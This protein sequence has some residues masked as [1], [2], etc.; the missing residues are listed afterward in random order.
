[1]E[2]FLCLGAR[3]QATYWEETVERLRRGEV[4]NCKACGCQYDARPGLCTCSEDC[5]G[6][7]ALQDPSAIKLF[8]AAVRLRPILSSSDAATATGQPQA[9]EEYFSGLDWG[10]FDGSNETVDHQLA[11][12]W[13]VGSEQKPPAVILAE[14]ATSAQDGTFQWETAELL[15][16]LIWT[17]E[18]KVEAE[19]M[20]QYVDA[21]YT[22]WDNVENLV[23]QQDELYLSLAM[24]NK[25]I[26]A[27]FRFLADDISR[28][29]VRD[30]TQPLGLGSTMFA[31]LASNCENARR[32]I[33][34]PHPYQKA[35]GEYSEMKLLAM[36]AGTPA[37]MML[38]WD[39]RLAD[40]FAAPSDEYLKG[41]ICALKR[42]V[43]LCIEVFRT[44]PWRLHWPKD[45][46]DDEI[47]LYFSVD[48]S[49]RFTNAK[50]ISGAMTHVTEF[51]LTHLHVAGVPD[52]SRT[53]HF[54]AKCDKK[55]AQENPLGRRATGGWT[56]A[57]LSQHCATLRQIIASEGT[58]LRA[59]EFVT[60]LAAIC[61][62]YYHATR[63]GELCPGALFD[64]HRGHWTKA[65]LK[66]VLQQWSALEDKIVL[67]LPQPPKKTEFSGAWA[68][69][70]C[71]KPLVFRLDDH[72]ELSPRRAM[73]EMEALCPTDWDRADTTPIFVNPRTGISLTVP[74]IMA[75]VTRVTW[76]RSTHG[77]D[78]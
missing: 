29:A 57:Q 31:S 20:Q 21:G 30:A 45:R 35:K 28:V 51:H 42:W 73:V 48:G 58:S 39:Q 5:T 19:A 22:T 36:Q 16:L 70:L 33:V 3:I 52:F 43:W 37:N 41:R 13:V 24:K 4:T 9:R 67:L 27:S 50:T 78:M 15:N 66:A 76:R 71:N 65:T 40:V 8:D 75:F 10:V 17:I 14:L 18:N 26:F 77:C 47:M 64:P 44:V 59:Q 62:T 7:W 69:Q 72:S 23:E 1:M 60:I 53:K 11:R 2:T 32:N 61:T 25:T 34:Q 56:P 63:T 6:S 46:N 12:E 74:R 68:R 38:V 55:L 54:I 49:I